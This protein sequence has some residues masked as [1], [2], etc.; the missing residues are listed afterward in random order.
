MIRLV[1]CDDKDDD[2]EDDGEDFFEGDA[3]GGFGADDE[4]PR[5]GG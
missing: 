5:G 1:G 2:C 3:S 4:W